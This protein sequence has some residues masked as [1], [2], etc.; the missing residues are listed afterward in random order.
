MVEQL[1]AFALGFSICGLIGLA[2]LPLV[3]ARARRLTL[4]GVEQQ[5]PMTFDEMEAERD[6]LRARFAVERRELELVAERERQLRAADSAELGRRTADIVRVEEVL[7]TTQEQLRQREDALAHMTEKSETL[8]AELGATKANLA[9]REAELRDKS[10]EFDALAEVHRLLKIEL[11]RMQSRLRE[12]EG[13]NENFEA[14]RERL[15]AK[16]EAERKLAEEAQAEADA[17]R[18]TLERGGGAEVADLRA[19]ILDIGRRVAGQAE[20]GAGQD[21][22]GQDGIGRDSVPEVAAQKDT[23]REEAAQ[24]ISARERA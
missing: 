18:G 8:F 14:R 6:L 2:F 1:V 11:E 12:S 24:K 20:N 9:E 13:R 23:P 17:L 4:K 15:M 22:W 5:L 10:G 7:R 19:A 21:N 16:I 3:S